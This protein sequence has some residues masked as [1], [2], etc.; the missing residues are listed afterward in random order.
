[1]VKEKIFPFIDT[2]RLGEGVAK[3]IGEAM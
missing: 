2:I 1:M 3:M